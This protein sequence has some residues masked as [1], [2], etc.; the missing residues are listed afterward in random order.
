VIE[1]VLVIVRRHR[2][3]LPRDLALLL[4][5]LVMDQGLAADLDPGFQLQQVLAPY[6]QRLMAR[7]FAPDVLARRLAQTGAEAAQLG[8]EFPGQLRR[9]LRVLDRGDLQVRLPE[10]DLELLIARTERT[11]NRIV[12]AVVAA[13]LIQASAGLIASGRDRRRS[14]VVGGVAAAGAL[15][16]YLASTARRTP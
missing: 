15:G 13:A 16:A 3:Q 2:L 10:A 12:A 4:K 5:V 7:Q 14:L 9:L 1:E 8:V 11:G 6:A